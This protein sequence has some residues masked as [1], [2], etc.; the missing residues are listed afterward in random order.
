MVE[1]FDILKFSKQ[2]QDNIFDTVAGILHLGNIQFKKA[3]EK[4]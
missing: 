4:I 1:A 2:E 3:G